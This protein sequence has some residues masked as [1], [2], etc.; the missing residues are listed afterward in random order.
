M[1]MSGETGYHSRTSC[2][3]CKSARVDTAFTLTPTPPAN[4][5]VPA[6]EIGAQQ[7]CYPLTLALCADCGHAQLREVVDPSILFSSYLYVSGTSPVYRQHLRTYADALCERFGLK[8]EQS[9]LEI[10]SNDGTLLGFF[11]E[12]GI[13][14]LGVDPAQN[15]ALEANKNGIET[16][17]TFFS[18]DLAT[19]LKESR[20]AFQLVVANHVFAHIDNLEDIALGVAELLDDDGI[21]VFEVGYF[22]DVYEQGYFDTIYHEHVS[23]HTVKPLVQFFHRIG[24]QVFDVQNTAA[25]GGSLRVFVQ[26]A[27]SRH[28][29]SDNVA[30]FIAAEEAVQLFNLSTFRRMEQS[31][32]TTRRDLATLLQSLTA[33][34][35][36]IAAY[37]APAKATTLMYHFGLTAA[38]ICYI[39]DDNPLK[40]GMF[41]PGLHIPIV[42]DTELAENPV[43]I[44]VILAWN[45]AEP[46]MK[47]MQPFAE[48]GGKFIVPF[49]VVELV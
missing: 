15:L 24:M 34:G 32:D 47:K 8:S 17:A 7:H 40:Q 44:L 26:K 16:L 46:I 22:K 9:V 45:F 41:T 4:A 37:G 31:V 21:F 35:K 3:L 13:Q 30:A 42:A 49:P 14:C 43:D 25:Q 36:R 1:S 27:S 48:K 19:S 5:Y 20:G 18:S 2:R 33:E 23:F 29:V 12:R 6:S 11:Q 39:I 10:G 38:D 28:A